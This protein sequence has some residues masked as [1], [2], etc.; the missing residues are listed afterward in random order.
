MGTL[1]YGAFIEFAASHPHLAV[2]TSPSARR[3]LE[4]MQLSAERM[5]DCVEDAIRFLKRAVVGFFWG[6][7]CTM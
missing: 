7:S 1:L 5:Y 6:L 2:A 3:A 4:A